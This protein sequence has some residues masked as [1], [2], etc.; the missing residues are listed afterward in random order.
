MGFLRSSRSLVNLAHPRDPGITAV[1]GM[2]RSS[3]GASVTPATVMG[4][5][6]AYRAVRLLARTMA[7]L[8][9]GVY[10]RLEDGSRRP[11]PKHPIHYLL[12]VRPNRW[13]TAF[14][15]KEMMAGHVELRGNAYAEIIVDGRGRVVEL[16]PRHPDRITVHYGVLAGG[17][18][19]T[20][21]YEYQPKSGPKRVILWDEMLHVR[22]FSQDG[23]IGLNPV[24]VAREAFG[25]AISNQDYAGKII[26]NDATPNGILKTPKF[27]KPTRRRRTGNRGRSATA[28]RTA[29]R[30]R[31][32]TMGWSGSR[33]AS[34]RSMPSSSSSGSSTSTRSRA[35]SI[36]R[37]TS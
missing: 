7:T 10:E 32:S 15:F 2:K 11:A 37:R 31:S 3:S 22:G 23:L 4:L 36:C 13:M 30:R 28:A 1:F 29:A 18:E 21:W 16:I 20:I 24:E 19:E 14:G 25:L 8:P 34:S 17:F 26:G 27:M 12:T 6:A 9:T 5:P 35:S 33:W